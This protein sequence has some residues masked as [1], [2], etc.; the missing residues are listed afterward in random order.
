MKL[1]SIVVVV[2]LGLS[3]TACSD[4]VKITMPTQSTSAITGQVISSGQTWSG[5]YVCRQGLTDVVIEVKNKVGNYHNGIYSFNY[6]NKDKGAF[7][8][9]IY[10]NGSNIYTKSAYWIDQPRNYVMVD[11]DGIFNP[12]KGTWNGSVVDAG[13]GN[14]DLKL[15]S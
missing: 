14:F 4:I 7:A 13:C 8:I 15:V 5:K 3:L 12:S 11:L 2:M 6:A 10:E 1:K 9:R